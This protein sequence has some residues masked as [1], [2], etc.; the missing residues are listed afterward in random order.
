LVEFYAPW[1]PHC[2]HFDKTFQKIG[3]S[4]NTETKLSR[5]NVYHVDCTKYPK[6]ATKFEVDGYPSV[7]VGTKKEFIDHYSNSKDGHVLKKLTGQNAKKLLKEIN[8]ATNSAVILHSPTAAKILS[9][10]LSSGPHRD[11][12]VEKYHQTQDEDLLKATGMLL[13]YSEALLLDEKADIEVAVLRRFLHSLS[14]HFPIKSCRRSFAELKFV[15]VGAK[16]NR[17]GILVDTH[18]Y[19]LSG[20]WDL[21]NRYTWAQLDSMKWK[22]CKG[23]NPRFRGYTCGLWTLFH[24]LLMD[25]TSFSLIHG[26]IELF[27]QCDECRT[28]FLRTT[29]NYKK[30]IG[31]RGS[32]VMYFWQIHNK[33]NAR[34][35]K[36]H[37][38][39]HE[40]DPMFPMAQWPMHSLC[41][42]CY[43]KNGE[44][45][46]YEVYKF[47]N[48]YYKKEGGGDG[49]SYLP[50]ARCVESKRCMVNHDWCI[51]Q[52]GQSSHIP[53]QCF[54]NLTNTSKEK[55]DKKY[56]N[57]KIE[58]IQY[59]L[60][61]FLL[62]D[63]SPYYP[64]E[65]F[66]GL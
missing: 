23:T 12:R 22:G 11:V 30:Y 62:Y 29:A 51:C 59:K 19:K 8:Q 40:G 16:K 4:F 6:L 9:A 38:Q 36:E 65:R 35:G 63:D 44:F 45:I 57:H 24:S 47:L 49:C 28:H 48:N 31:D 7:L 54:P 15:P 66:L 32:R 52:E 46:N 1:C 17:K 26:W 2:Q 21:C 14:E 58:K 10:K 53:T 56:P 60:L 20:K 18:G 64:G 5:V 42:N 3:F 50:L 27:F 43:D 37:A 55:R 61:N 33:V 41:S 25:G 34:I 39:N 13:K